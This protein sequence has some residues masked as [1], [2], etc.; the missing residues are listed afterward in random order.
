MFVYSCTAI[1]PIGL[2]VLNLVYTIVLFSVSAMHVRMCMQLQ[3]YMYV[4][5][6]VV[7]L[8][9]CTAVPMAVPTRQ[10]RTAV[11]QC[12]K[13]RGILSTKVLLKSWADYGCRINFKR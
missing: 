3:L 5:Y 2:H 10:V 12:A 9:S 4:Y 7:Q 1:R 13:S 11:W 8:Y 6:T